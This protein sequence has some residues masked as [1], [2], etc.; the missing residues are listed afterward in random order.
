MAEVDP[1]RTQGKH[2]DAGRDSSR[3]LE[4]WVLWGMAFIGVGGLGNRAPGVLS[5]LPLM[6]APLVFLGVPSVFVAC[7]PPLLHACVRA[8]SPSRNVLRV[9]FV[10]L[11]VL[12]LFYCFEGWSY[13]ARWQ[14]STYCVL[15]CL[16]NVGAALASA[17]AVFSRTHSPP[18][19]RRN[20]E[21]LLVAW[22]CSYAFPYFGEVL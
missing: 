5:P 3:L 13:G 22:L 4:A 9:G 1:A 15:V 14:D 6:M 11:L 21:W 18:F 12:S 2:A 20:P 10:S 8:A 7:L 17:H 16:M 19:R